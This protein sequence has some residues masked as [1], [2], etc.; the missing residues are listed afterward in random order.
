MRQAASMIRE[1]L[2]Q[3]GLPDG[4]GL[5]I[6]QRDD[7]PALAMA[8]A[9]EPSALDLIVAERDTRSSSVRAR[10]DE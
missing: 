3:A 8:L 1:L 9:D 2:D 4:A 6:A 10:Y 5:R 7:H